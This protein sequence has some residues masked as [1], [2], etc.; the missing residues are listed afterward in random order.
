MVPIGYPGPAHSASFH[1]DLYTGPGLLGALV[2]IINLVLLFVVF[3]EHRVLDDEH[4]NFN[5]QSSASGMWN[6][7]GGGGLGTQC[8]MYV[9]F[10]KK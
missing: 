2:G 4:L 10:W 8:K 3:R 6:G 5:V 1:L 9:C 7:C